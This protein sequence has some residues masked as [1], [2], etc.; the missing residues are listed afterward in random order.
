MNVHTLLRYFFKIKSPRLRMAGLWLFHVTGRRYL[1]A[2]FDPVVA[3]NLRC[4][5]C[6]FSVAGGH[7]TQPPMPWDQVER[8]ADALFHRVMKLQIGCGAEPTLYPRLAD[9]VA[10]GKRKGIPYVSITTNGK[11]LTAVSLEKLAEA[12]LDELTLSAHGLTQ[13]TYESLM[14]R[15]SFADFQRVLRD[16][17]ELKKR[18]PGFKL[19]INYTVN[20]DNWRDLLQFPRVFAGV[21]V[22]LVQIRPV[23]DL[24]ESDYRNFSLE[25][26][27]RNYDR[28]FP[29]IADFCRQHAITLL[30]PQPRHLQVLTEDAPAQALSVQDYAYCYI[31][32]SCC[33]KSDFHYAEEDFDAY[34]RR[35]HVGSELWNAIWRRRKPA[36]EKWKT[37]PLNYDVK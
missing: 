25:A 23:Q 24:G 6:Y 30:Y 12:G 21:P 17:T 26:I 32:T 8:V 31:S 3:C 27:A 20:E 18:F 36:G 2:F 28:V 14:P 37:R 33:W 9:L 5:M 19:R 11:L 22:D 35:N 7:E 1:G 10:L 13:A 29:P 16:V 4:R 15:G 34:C